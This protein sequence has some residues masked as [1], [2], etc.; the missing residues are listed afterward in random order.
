M[1]V[2]LGLLTL[3]EEHRLREIE[4]G[5]LWEVFGAKREEV[6]EDWRQLHSE[7]LR[8]LHTALTDKMG[9][10]RDAYRMLVE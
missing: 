1:G 4:N 10:M 8:D 3:S 2:K 9:E 6:T 5:V 7:E